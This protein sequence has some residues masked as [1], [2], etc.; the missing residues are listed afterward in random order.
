[1]VLGPGAR[2]CEGFY[3]KAVP[4]PRPGNPFITQKGRC[5]QE[6]PPGSSS[7]A[8]KVFFPSTPFSQRPPAAP[9][10]GGSFLPQT[11]NL[12]SGRGQTVHQEGS[13]VD[14]TEAD[15]EE[16]N[17]HFARAQ[18]Q[19]PKERPFRGR[20]SGSY[21]L[22]GVPG[23]RPGSSYNCTWLGGPRPGSPPVP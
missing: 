12:P 23:Q 8:T 19:T 4:H 6:K 18:G 15:Q 2:V 14:G 1:M 11:Q 3:S 17:L 20:I 21:P 22:T 16:K 5:S 13:V 7:Q 10:H 9:C